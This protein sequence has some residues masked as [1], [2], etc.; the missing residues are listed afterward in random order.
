M[1]ACS[2]QGSPGGTQVRKANRSR[3]VIENAVPVHKDCHPKGQ[4]A[5]DFK[6][7]WLAKK[8]KSDADLALDELMA[9]K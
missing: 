5:I 6:R 1:S 8:S 3:A 9:R 4:K 2:K 7:Q